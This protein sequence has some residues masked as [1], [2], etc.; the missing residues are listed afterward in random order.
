MEPG[1][2]ADEPDGD[3]GSDAPHGATSADELGETSA[4]GSIPADT[5]AAVA[6]SEPGPDHAGR[7]TAEI[8]VPDDREIGEEATLGSLATATYLIVCP[9]GDPDDPGR[10][11]AT[12]GTRPEG[13]SDGSGE[14]MF[15]AE[16]PVMD[17]GWDEPLDRPRRHEGQV[18]IE[19]Q[20]DEDSR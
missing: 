20:E 10:S 18:A 2:A 1:P 6:L 13:E 9:A 7:N 17:A 11:L 5:E 15:R 19:D 14:H 4:A 16:M 3:S 12:S 8:V